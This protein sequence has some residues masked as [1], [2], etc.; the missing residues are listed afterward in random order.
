MTDQPS[1]ALSAWSQKHVL[2]PLKAER[3]HQ[4]FGLLPP[5]TQPVVAHLNP[6]PSG[7]VGITVIACFSTREGQHWQLEA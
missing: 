3:V 4:N 5:A 2:P 6:L 1:T 7:K